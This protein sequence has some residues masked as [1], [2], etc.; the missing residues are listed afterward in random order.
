[1]VGTPEYHVTRCSL[2]VRQKESALNLV[3]TT[4]VPPESR[5]AMVEPINPWTWNNGMMH[6]ETSS[7]VRAYAFA[8]FADETA[9]LKCRKGTR[10]GRPVLPLVCR[11]RAMSS[12]A[13]AVAETAVVEAP[14]S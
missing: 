7:S 3:G 9:R 10:L 5:V 11:T 8:I 1:M 13:G 12:A 6:S 4:N 2:T 14:T